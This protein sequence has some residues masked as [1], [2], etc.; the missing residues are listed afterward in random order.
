MT[1]GIEYSVK[2]AL[3]DKGFDLNYNPND[4]KYRPWYRVPFKINFTNRNGVGNGNM[5][6]RRINIPTNGEYKTIDDIAGALLHETGHLDIFP[7]E[8]P[9]VICGLSQVADQFDDPI[10]GILAT[11]GVM[12]GYLFAVRELIVEGYNCVKHGAKK[13]LNLRWGDD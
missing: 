8:F 1:Q 2:E 10:K 9:L 13:Y 6:L 11:I 4:S 3:E 12:A 5:V 7:V